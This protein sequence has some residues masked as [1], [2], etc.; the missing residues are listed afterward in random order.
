[1]RR[2]ARS[3][4]DQV[5]AFL[6]RCIRS[7]GCLMG[8]QRGYGWI[9]FQGRRMQ[10]HRAVY[11]VKVGPIP[12]GLVIRHTCDRAGCVE[13]DH[14]IL[15]TIA[16]NNQDK[17]D[18]DQQ[19]I[20]ELHPAAT[21]SDEDVRSAVALYRQGGRSQA[22][23]G[24]IFGVTQTQVGRWVRAESRATAG[25]VPIQLGKGNSAHA[26]GLRPCGTKAAY[27]RHIKQ[28]T[29]VCDDCRQ[30]HRDYMAAYRRN[31]RLRAA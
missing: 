5:E 31:R 8:P 27:E 10:A 21:R 9:G 19:P 28:K 15:G 4:P 20:G 11:T 16:D 2:D 25:Q 1:M 30:A 3:L 29:P 17:F 14:L 26:R 23:I 12:N 24:R 6:A 13:V 7:N 22:E 18:R